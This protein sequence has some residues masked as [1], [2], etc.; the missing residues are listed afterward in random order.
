MLLRD[1]IRKGKQVQTCTPQETLQQVVEK[2]VHHNIGSLVVLEGQKM[3][4]I[5]TERDILKCAAAH[6]AQ[7]GEGLVRDCMTRN[8]KTV[9]DDIDLTEVMGIMTEHRI[10][11][12]PILTNG[13]LSGMISIG[14]VV[15][16][17]HDEL[18]QEN[19]YLKSYIQS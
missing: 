12:L 11:H 19:H 18:S 8:P 15:K 3:A 17:Q 1:V 10:R 7:Y 5:I 2:L 14:D 16:A 9:T 13:E 4:G 6:G